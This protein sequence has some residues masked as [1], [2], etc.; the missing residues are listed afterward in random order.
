MLD[1][2]LILI[3]MAFKERSWSQVIILNGRGEIDGVTCTNGGRMNFFFYS[4]K[5]LF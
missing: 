1:I 2:L 4:N 5:Y 3:I